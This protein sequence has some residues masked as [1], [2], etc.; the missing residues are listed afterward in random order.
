MQPFSQPRLRNALIYKADSTPVGR[1]AFAQQERRSR[2]R[3]DVFS[4]FTSVRRQ[5]A[6]AFFSPFFLLFLLPSVFS[7][8]RRRFVGKR[9]QSRRDGD[10]I[11]DEAARARRRRFYPRFRSN[12][13]SAPVGRLNGVFRGLTQASPFKQ[14]RLKLLTRKQLRVLPRSGRFRLIPT[15]SGR[16]RNRF[17]NRFRNLFTTS[18]R[19][20]QNRRRAN[21]SHGAAPS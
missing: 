16:R 20:W 11:V 9:L 21:V 8:N 2:R 12:S 6:N 18:T 1:A 15:R 10:I 7:Q 4:N 13:V 5:L 3:N 17:R 19:P 14:L